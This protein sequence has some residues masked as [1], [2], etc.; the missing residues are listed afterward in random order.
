MS[1][2]AVS[3]PARLLLLTIDYPPLGGG[4]SRW[5]AL[6]ARALHPYDVTVL[7]PETPGPAKTG[8]EAE[9]RIRIVRGP[10]FRDVPRSWGLHDLFSYAR[11]AN[12]L[13]QETGA[14]LILSAQAG[15]PALVGAVAARRRRVPFVMAA[16]GEE[17]S[18]SMKSPVRRWVLRR[19]V[20]AAA[21]LIANSKSTIDVLVSLGADR[22]RTRRWAAVDGDEWGNPE[23]SPERHGDP[24]VLLTVGRIDKRKGQEKMLEAWPAVRQR[25]PDCE[26]WIVGGGPGVDG[27]R[28]RVRDDPALLGVRIFGRVEDSRLEEMYR[29]ASVFV[30]TSRRVAGLEEGLGLVFLEAALFGVPSV[31]GRIGGVSDAVVHEKTGLL[32]DP[33]DAGEIARA[34][35]RLLAD[36]ELRRTM[37][38]RARRRVH[39]L[40]VLPQ[41]SRRLVSWVEALLPEEK[42]SVR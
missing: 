38:H 12:R 35:I 28:A 37:G 14:N 15:L 33:E 32:V 11:W 31:G 16:H 23:P 29:R 24:P 7:A 4:I 34:V 10:F 39:R 18:R 36:G 2:P 41:A 13:S 25:F 27:L 40:F 19:A 22:S 9:D 21:L 1:G 8:R 6:L 26:Y 5:T 17:L 42:R 20:A 30:L 3:A